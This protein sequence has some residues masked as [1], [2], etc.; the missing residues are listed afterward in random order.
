MKDDQ[1]LSTAIISI[2]WFYLIFGT[3]SDY[4][5][6]CYRVIELRQT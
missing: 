3:E 6:A 1:T 5:C 4:C 2:L